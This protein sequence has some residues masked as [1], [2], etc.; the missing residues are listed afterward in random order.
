MGEAWLCLRKNKQVTMHVKPTV[1]LLRIYWWSCCDFSARYLEGRD[2]GF[3][4][5]E[6]KR[7]VKLPSKTFLLLRMIKGFLREFVV[8][9]KINW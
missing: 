5:M 6:W 1:V 7:F 2:R 4:G 3:R 9:Y 8:I